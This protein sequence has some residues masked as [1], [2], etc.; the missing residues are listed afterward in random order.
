M[1]ILQ[2]IFVPILKRNTSLGPSSALS[3][4]KKLKLTEYVPDTDAVKTPVVRLIPGM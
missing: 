1:Q 3:D 4:V 2:V